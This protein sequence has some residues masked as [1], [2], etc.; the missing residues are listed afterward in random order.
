MNFSVRIDEPFSHEIVRTD[1]EDVYTVSFRQL[2]DFVNPPARCDRINTGGFGIIDPLDTIESRF[3]RS[4]KLI[5][6]VWRK[7]LNPAVDGRKI[8]RASC[9]ERGKR[10]E[11]NGRKE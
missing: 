3:L 1:R 10:E 4:G 7:K 6:P 11:V 9:R 2:T 5:S 8:G